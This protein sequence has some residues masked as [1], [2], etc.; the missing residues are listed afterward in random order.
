MNYAEQCVQA[1]RE[2]LIALLQAKINGWTR[3]AKRL[4]AI[5]TVDGER[6]RKELALQYRFLCH[7][8]EKVQKQVESG[9]KPKKVKRPA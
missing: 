8:L 5:E 1:E 2:R 4:A 3:E 9:F 6:M 7:E